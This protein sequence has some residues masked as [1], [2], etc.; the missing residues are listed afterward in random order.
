M[1]LLLGKIPD[2]KRYNQF[3]IGIT[4]EMRQKIMGAQKHFTV[5]DTRDKRSGEQDYFFDDD[6]FS[7]LHAYGIAFVES[8]DNGN[9]V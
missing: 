1:R 8:A 3:E 7:S 4:N 6:F 2:I 9:I 5:I